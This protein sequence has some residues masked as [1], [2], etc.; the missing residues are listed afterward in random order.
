MNE[1]RKSFPKGE[2]EMIPGAGHFV[3][4]ERPKE[5]LEMVKNFLR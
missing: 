4:A 5:F 1:L 3:H 2:L